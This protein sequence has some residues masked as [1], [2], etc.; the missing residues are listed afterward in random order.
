VRLSRSPSLFGALLFQAAVEWTERVSKARPE[1]M[2]KAALLDRRVHLFDECQMLRGIGSDTAAI[3][4]VINA[5]ESLSDRLGHLA[6]YL[7]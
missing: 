3:V 1:V 7:G 4:H 6:S 5:L 2:S